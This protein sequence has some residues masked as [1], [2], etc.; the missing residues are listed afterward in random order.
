[1]AE[2]CLN[3]AEAF[4]GGVAHLQLVLNPSSHARSRSRTNIVK[5]VLETYLAKP[6]RLSRVSRNAS[7]WP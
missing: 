2:F 5:V 3:V 7:G 6:K 4:G 1:M